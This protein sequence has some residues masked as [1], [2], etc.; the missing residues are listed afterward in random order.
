MLKLK[1]LNQKAPLNLFVA[2]ACRALRLIRF[3]IPLK[4][5]GHYPLKSSRLSS[6]ITMISAPTKSRWLAGGP[7][8]GRLAIDETVNDELDRVAVTYRRRHDGPFLNLLTRGD[9]YAVH[10]ATLGMVPIDM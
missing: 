7:R 10:C 1:K 5:G 4:L 3:P 9:R 2:L 8:S 6:Q